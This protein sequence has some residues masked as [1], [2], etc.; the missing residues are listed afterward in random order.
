MWLRWVYC[1]SAITK[2]RLRDH[3]FVCETVLIRG[4]C[5]WLY[6]STKYFT[7]RLKVGSQFLFYLCTTDQTSH[8]SLE[9][10]DDENTQD[11]NVTHQYSACFCEKKNAFGFQ[12]FLAEM[13]FVSTT[14]LHLALKSLPWCR[15]D[16]IRDQHLFSSCV[17]NL[18]VFL[19]MSRTIAL[20]RALR[21]AEFA[22]RC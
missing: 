3:I 16:N 9:A 8:H 15:T 7:Q 13:T 4:W 14:V 20:L 2:Y 6:V 12:S 21:C 10:S 11:R 18:V 17:H 22:S 1:S 5:V 19:Q